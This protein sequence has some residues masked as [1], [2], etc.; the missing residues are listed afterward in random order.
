MSVT[1]GGVENINANYDQSKT[2]IQLKRHYEQSET[3]QGE[4]MQTHQCYPAITVLDASLPRCLALRRLVF[5]AG[6]EGD[7]HAQIRCCCFP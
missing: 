6:C 1:S 5:G 2:P 3:T 7:C 4:C